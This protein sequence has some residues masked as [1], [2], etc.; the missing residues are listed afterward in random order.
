MPIDDDDFHDFDPYEALVDLSQML[1]DLSASHK[2][3]VE[4]Y[5]ATLKRLRNVELRISMIQKQLQEKP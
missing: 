4:D 3:L 5:T 1:A 2:I